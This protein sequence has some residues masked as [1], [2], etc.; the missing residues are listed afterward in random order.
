LYPF[1]YVIDTDFFIESFSKA[2]P[3]VTLYANDTALPMIVTPETQFNLTCY[4]LAPKLQWHTLID[5]PPAEWRKAFD[6]WIRHETRAPDFSADKPAFFYILNNLLRWPFIYDTNDFVAQFGRILRP[7]EDTRRIAGA[8][9][10]SMSEIYKLNLDYSSPAGQLPEGK[11]MGAHLRT[12]ADATKVG[13]P[14]YDSQETNYMHAANMSNLDLI[15]LTTGAPDDAK[16]FTKTAKNNGITV[17][18]KELLLKGKDFKQER[19]ILESLTWDQRALVDLEVLFRCSYFV[20]MFESSFS[21]NVALRRHVVT[22][23]GTWLTI[24]PGKQGLD[25]LV[26]P[27][28]A[29]MDKYSAVYGPVDLGIRWQFPMALFP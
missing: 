11:F 1:S 12:A 20:G 5:M 13:W 28:E 22:G 21:W 6:D 15:Y 18:S 2:C 17:T 7:R 27:A 3:Q 29:F 14:G 4:E 10:W 23:N 9:L 25:G 19:K 26:D 16:R 8:V 24:E